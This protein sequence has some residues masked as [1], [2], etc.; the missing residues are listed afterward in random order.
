MKTRLR[1]TLSAD[2][3]IAESEKATEA[4]K[5]DAA[6]MAA[7]VE[8]FREGHRLRFGWFFL[9]GFTRQLAR[10]FAQRISWPALFVSVVIAAEA[11]RATPGWELWA[12]GWSG[13]LL[14][15]WMH[16]GEWTRWDRWRDWQERAGRRIGY[17]VRS[18]IAQLNPRE[19]RMRKG[20]ELAS[21]VHSTFGG[22]MNFYPGRRD[23]DDAT[24]LVLCALEFGMMSAWS[25]EES[26]FAIVKSRKPWDSWRAV[27][28]AEIKAEM[29]R[30]STKCSWWRRLA[31][32]Q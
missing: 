28:A 26:W 10:E 19:R 29:K 1:V 5:Q 27:S 30:L 7:R 21:L 11:S 8:A 18:R 32:L 6:V 17:L 14:G 23:Q 16:R 22:C 13:Y 25:H 3:W 9:V 4:T 15:F 20:R 2:Q 12:C 24:R 31:G